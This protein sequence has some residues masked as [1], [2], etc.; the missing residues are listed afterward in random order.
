MVEAAVGDCEPGFSP[1]EIIAIKTREREAVVPAIVEPAFVGRAADLEQLRRVLERAGAG[2]GCVALLVG[3]PGVGKTRLAREFGARADAGGAIVLWG[4]AY[5]DWTP[6]YGPWTQA[7]TPFVDSRDDL[8]T[9]LAVLA[10]VV[11]TLRGRS[12]ELSPAPPLGAREEQFRLHDAV[13][14]V[15][16]REQ[17]TVVVML[18]DLQWADRASLELLLGVARSSVGVLVV[19][20]MRDEWR[21]EI[22][23][24]CLAELSRGRLLRRLGVSPL[25]EGDSALLLGQIMG[26]PVPESVAAAVYAQAQG[27][28][29][30]TE[31]LARHVHD[32]GA[33]T[34]P[35]SVRL[36]VGARVRRLSSEAARVLGVASVFTRPFRFRAVQALADLSEEAVLDAL[37]E[38]LAARLL[39]VA[40]ARAE[41][42]EFSHALVRQALYEELNPSR[43]VRLHRRAAHALEPLDDGSELETAAELAAQYHRSASLPGA[44]HGVGYAL[45][46]AAAAH[47]NYAH[48]EAARLLRMASDL[49]G[50]I[51]VAQRAQIVC[52]LALAEAEAL[53]LESALQ[54][55]DAAQAALLESGESAEATAAFLWKLARTLKDAGAA[56]EQLRPLVER[57]LRL[58]GAERSLLWARLKLVPRPTEPLVSGR[59]AAERWLGYDAEAVRIAR[60][61]GDELDYSATLELMDRRSY[62]EIG[63]LLERCQGWR[64]P[65]ARIHALSIAARTLLYD[66]GAFRE[67]QEVSR[68]LLAESERV[69]SLPGVA[70]ALEQLADVEIAFGDFE[71]ATANLARARATAAKL[72]PAHRVHFIIGLVETRLAM[73]LNGEWDALARTYELAATNPRLPWPW[74][75]IHA[76]AW[77]ALA[78]ARAGAAPDASRLLDELFPLL[79]TL[80][81]TTLNQNAASALAGEAIWQL[82]D[83]T[84]A[85]RCRQLTLALIDA[86]T[87][88]YVMGAQALTMARMAS[89]LE[90]HSEAV[91]WFERAQAKLRA[92]GR[93]PLRVIALVDQATA[94][95]AARAPLPI[96]ELRE[97]RELA[98]ELGMTGWTERAA[99]LLE[100]AEA[101]PPAGLTGRESEILRFLAEGLTNREIADTLVL[102]VHTIERH[103]ANAYR[104]I[105]ARNRADATAFALRNL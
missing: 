85:E 50:E 21:S 37:D 72:G 77:A 88:D 29:F 93:R 94:A 14:R 75:T 47:A 101:T 44:A 65:V 89:L 91:D 17:R 34:I 35:D 13:A 92:D 9:D 80:P 66:L 36:A 104:K 67:A 87:G 3:E 48:A 32:Q 97:A 28:A 49:A 20:T 95:H 73:Y 31:E 69:G 83:P 81:P 98:T 7:L 24:H 16:D 23:A 2:E 62:D 40:S 70:Y 57:G 15:L 1:S 64:E 103:L 5:E 71:A 76:A 61:S 90:E 27:N 99:A 105:G 56:E 59:I 43:R 74:I 41:S 33:V 82:H 46:A 96:R 19:A 86:G 45:A 53:E 100:Q 26:G 51:D 42:Y 6:P 78:H 79:E 84:R 68:D 39:A 10:S 4:A 30:F 25:G 11:P 55:A 12:P 22:L 58:V 63:D 60:C 52:R 18:D 54:T 38:A 8:G 102:S